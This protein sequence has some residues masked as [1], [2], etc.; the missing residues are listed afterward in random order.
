MTCFREWL[1]SHKRNATH[2]KDS[3]RGVEVEVD[4]LE[5]YFVRILHLE[6]AHDHLPRS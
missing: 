4:G 2:L 5:R 3:G 6:H 1:E